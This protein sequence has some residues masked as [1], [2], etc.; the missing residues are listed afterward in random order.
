ML[1]RLVYA[2]TPEDQA[3]LKELAE[4]G[5]YVRNIAIRLKRSESS[6]KKRARELGIKVRITPR[7]PFRFQ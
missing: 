1:K 5:V 2:W 4:Q 7:T 6:I 3:K